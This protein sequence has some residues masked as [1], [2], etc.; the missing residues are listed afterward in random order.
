M[1]ITPK[2]SQNT[3]FKIWDYSLPSPGASIGSVQIYNTGGWRV[4]YDTNL[5]GNTLEV[6]VNDVIKPKGIVTR[7]KTG[8]SASCN[9]FLFLDFWYSK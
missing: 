3:G 4:D 7:R 8:T 6:V 2:G 5:N 9:P 1:K